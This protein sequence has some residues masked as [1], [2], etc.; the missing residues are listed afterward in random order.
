[1]FFE[2]EINADGTFSVKAVDKTLSKNAI[3]AAKNFVETCCQHA[4]FIG[5]SGDVDEEIK[6]LTAGELLTINNYY[7][8]PYILFHIGIT[9]PSG[10]SPNATA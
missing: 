3:N 4:A 1:M 5:G 2:D 10:T 6:S 8:V 7:T 9:H